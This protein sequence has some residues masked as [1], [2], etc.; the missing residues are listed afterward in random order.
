[1]DNFLK[2]RQRPLHIGFTVYENWNTPQNSSVGAHV[3]PISS[4]PFYAHGLKGQQGAC[5]V[6]IVGLYVKASV[7]HKLVS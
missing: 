3:G 4:L 5:S 6:W 2:S 7:F 1:M